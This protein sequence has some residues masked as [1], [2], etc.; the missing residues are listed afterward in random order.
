M[1]ISGNPC[2]Q[3]MAPDVLLKINFSS[4]RDEFHINEPHII[5]V[6]PLIPFQ[7]SS[8]ICLAPFRRAPCLSSSQ[9]PLSKNALTGKD[10]E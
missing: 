10:M 2:L 3:A 5:D 1:A 9:L 4:I 7:I 6:F 8:G